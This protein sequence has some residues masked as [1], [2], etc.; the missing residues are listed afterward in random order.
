MK[1]ILIKKLSIKINVFILSCFVFNLNYV[2]SD[3]CCD[4]L[5]SNS[6]GKGSKTNLE[7]IQLSTQDIETIKTILTFCYML[8]TNL[9]FNSSN[10][11][12]AGFI[13]GAV[14]SID[15]IQSWQDVEALVSTFNCVKAEPLKN[16]IYLKNNEV[17]KDLFFMFSENGILHFAVP[18]ILK[19]QGFKINIPIV[20]KLYKGGNKALGD[21]YS[22]LS[23]AD[24]LVLFKFDQANDNHEIYNCLVDMDTLSID[25]YNKESCTDINK[26]M[27]S[28][29]SNKGKTC[30]LIGSFDDLKNL[31]L[32]TFKP[33]YLFTPLA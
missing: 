9:L 4:C 32:N 30:Y 31:D 5:S 13:S 18:F 27:F 12:S 29:V 1:Q 14:G 11:I 6:G 7:G 15:K 24:K 16:Y 22:K 28:I 25:G 2:F 3:G 8:K 20:L 26:A 21:Y 23:E 17:D 19:T 33:K 10:P